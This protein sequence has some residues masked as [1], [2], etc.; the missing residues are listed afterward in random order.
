MEKNEIVNVVAKKADTLLEAGDSEDTIHGLLSLLPGGGF[1]DSVL[2]RR[3]KQ[4]A[5]KRLEEFHEKMANDLKFLQEAKIDKEFLESEEFDY[6]VMKVVSRTVWEHSE[7]KR[8]Y[9]RNFL[10]NTIT[11]DFS[12][13]PL[14]ETLL[15]LIGGISPSHIKMMQFISK[16]MARTKSG[17]NSLADLSKKIDTMSESVAEAIGYD[18]FQKGLIDREYVEHFTNYE[19]SALGEQLL[20]FIKK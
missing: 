18:L 6:L 9:L 4:A 12:K 17:W 5:R 11:L 15:E 1:L 19:L 20:L 16:G 10:I 3:V 8:E 14:K 13:N 2:F 7:Q